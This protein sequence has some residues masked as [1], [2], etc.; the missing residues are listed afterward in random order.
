MYYMLASA[1][2]RASSGV[3][4]T[5]R[6]KMVDLCDSEPGVEAVHSSRFDG[7]ASWVRP[8][9][10]CSMVGSARRWGRSWWRVVV[11]V[12]G[13]IAALVLGASPA[14]A[15]P[16]DPGG[17]DPPPDCAA[18]TTGSLT[19]TPGTVVA[20]GSVTVSWSIQQVAGCPTLK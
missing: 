9:G 17:G 8:G 7:A 20:G 18:G 3:R 6:R 12:V 15:V 13:S 5:R 1:Y 2:R 19:V 10:R 4:D 16:T 14:V 11:P